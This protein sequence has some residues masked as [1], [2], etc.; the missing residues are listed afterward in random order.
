MNGARRSAGFCMAEN[1]GNQIS[2]LVADD[3]AAIRLVLRHR[4]EAAGHHVEETA[5]SAST[6]EALKSNRFDVAL[7]DIMMPGPGGLEVLSAA[8]EAKARTLVIVITAATTMVN[9]V[10]AMKRG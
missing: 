2:V 7:V 8:R 6:L 5:D 1:N 10:E 9:A 4:L 3:D